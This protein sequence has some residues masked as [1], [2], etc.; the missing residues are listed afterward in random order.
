MP[1]SRAHN[2]TVAVCVHCVRFV[3]KGRARACRRTPWIPEPDR[4]VPRRRHN[5]VGCVSVRET[6]HRGA[7]RS[8]VRRH[9]SVQV[10]RVD[11]PLERPSKPF[12]RR[13]QCSGEHRSPTMVKPASSQSSGS[14]MRGR[15]MG[16]CRAHTSRSLNWER[17]M[18]KIVGDIGCTG[19]TSTQSSTILD[20]SHNRTSEPS[21]PTMSQK[22]NCGS[23][24]YGGHGWERVLMIWR[25]LGSNEFG[26]TIDA[27]RM[28]NESQHSTTQRRVKFTV[29]W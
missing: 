12:D 1:T 21:C 17:N 6:P 18:R 3:R 9:P 19:L 20:S 28:T 25:C 11:T 4:L 26:G 15:G 24:E 27:S 5:G 2:Y 16:V 7:V 8:E 13:R 29:V 10:K 23:E 22:V 14:S